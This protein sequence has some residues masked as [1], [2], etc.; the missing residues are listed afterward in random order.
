MRVKM[1][2]TRM[3][4]RRMIFF[5]SDAQHIRVLQWTDRYPMDPTGEPYTRIAGRPPMRCCR[6]TACSVLQR[7]RCC[8]V[9]LRPTLPQQQR[10]GRPTE[11][12]ACM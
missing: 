7:R 2:H 3:C 4:G 9:G 11:R 6:S 10:K 12:N 1:T 5:F 8:R